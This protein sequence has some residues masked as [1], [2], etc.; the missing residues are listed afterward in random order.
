MSRVKGYD[1]C[2]R[3]SDNINFFNAILNDPWHDGKPFFIGRYLTNVGEDDRNMDKKMTLDEVRLLAKNNIKIVSIF[4]GEIDGY[5]TDRGVINARTAVEA[6]AALSQPADTPIYFAIERGIESETEER[7][8]RSYLQ[9]V[10]SVLA[11]TSEN[12]NRYKLGVY[13]PQNRCKK[14]K[15]EWYTDAYTM[16]GHPHGES[17]SGWT[18][19]QDYCPSGYS[20]NLKDLVDF[21]ISRTSDYGGW[22]YHQYPASWSNYGSGIKHRKKCLYCDK[23]IYEYHTPDST[24]T[25]CTKCGYTGAIAIPTVEKGDEDRE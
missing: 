2:Q 22:L 21:N 24:G 17:Y 14:V 12:P 5:S 16:F 11:D 10:V 1:T 4:Q 6:A 20:G 25:R 9:G 18:I 19:E 13:G 23:Y 8:I 7:N 3:L 15:E